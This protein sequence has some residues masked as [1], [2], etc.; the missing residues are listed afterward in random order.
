MTR[1]KRGKITVRMRKKKVA[2]SKGFRW[3]WA[4]LSRPML[5]G[6]LKAT[7]YSYQHRTKRVNAFRRLSI[8]RSN[9]LIRACGLPLTYNKFIGV[10]NSHKC[11]LNRSSLVQLGIRDN[12]AFLQVMKFL[13]SSN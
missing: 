2:R 5:Q 8:L 12:V 11:K 13:V 4:V 10:S 7:N 3:A 6:Y 9:A 1:V